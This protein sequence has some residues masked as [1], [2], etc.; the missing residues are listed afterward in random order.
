MK[1][2]NKQRMTIAQRE[3]FQ[4]ACQL[5]YGKIKDKHE[6][7]IVARCNIVYQVALHMALENQLKFGEQRR[8]KFVDSFINSV[9][10]LSTEL[11]DNKALYNVNGHMIEDYDIEGN[12]ELL[13]RAC[14]YYGVK[15]DERIFDDELLYEEEVK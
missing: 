4:K 12:R 14:E 13:K 10:D 6:K 11:A 3:R 15:Y 8:K 9:N 7:M 1:F 2:N 5:E